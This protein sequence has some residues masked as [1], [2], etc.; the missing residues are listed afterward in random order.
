MCV[1]VCTY[2]GVCA[3]IYA[4]VHSCSADQQKS[5]AGNMRMFLR[6]SKEAELYATPSADTIRR[7]GYIVFVTI[8]SKVTPITNMCVLAFQ[9]YATANTSSSL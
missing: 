3:C 8:C 4:C 9:P 6:C 2:V 5:R 7:E 1:C